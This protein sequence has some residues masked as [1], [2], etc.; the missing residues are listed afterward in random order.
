MTTTIE[1][2]TQPIQPVCRVRGIA[3]VNA[4]ETSHAAALN[5]PGKVMCGGVTP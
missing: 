4:R 2:A 5:Q 3:M 1:E